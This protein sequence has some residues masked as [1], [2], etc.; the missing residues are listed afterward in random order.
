MTPPVVERGRGYAVVEAGPHQ[1]TWNYCSTLN[2][3]RKLA[4]ERQLNAG[5]KV[6]VFPVTTMFEPD[7]KY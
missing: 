2:E 5:C 1:C 4:R 6:F 3:A 7:M